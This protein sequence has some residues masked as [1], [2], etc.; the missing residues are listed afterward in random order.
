[1]SNRLK[2]K[3]IGALVVATLVSA[4]AGAVSRQTSEQDRDTSGRFDGPWL[5][6]VAKGAGVQYVHN[7]SVEC[8][9]MTN[10]FEIFIE[11][12]TINLKSDAAST[13]AF[14]STEG[15]FK[16][17]LPL[18]GEASSSS[19]SD[20]TLANGDRKLILSGRL[21]GD[22]PVGIITYGIAEL[23]WGGCTSKTSFSRI[24]PSV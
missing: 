3:L 14:V 10:E 15:N 20:V 16:L 8:D 1:M 9:D 19:R 17:S 13:R 22:K 2:L 4:C 12:G 23:G 6:T 11:D 21:G 24:Q 18:T 5:V 7:W